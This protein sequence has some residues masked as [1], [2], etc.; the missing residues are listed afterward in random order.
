M[1]EKKHA[2]VVRNKDLGE[3][4][5]NDKEYTKDLNEAM[6]FSVRQNAREFIR[7]FETVEQET[8]MK[9]LL[10][11]GKRLLVNRNSQIFLNFAN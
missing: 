8:P 5:K 2:W 7:D 4:A 9:V 6:L 1:T 10:L 11:N 3:Y